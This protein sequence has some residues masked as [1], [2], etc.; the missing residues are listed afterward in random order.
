MR[1]VLY[2]TNGHRHFLHGN[3]QIVLGYETPSKG[4]EPTPKT[5]VM[6]M[7]LNCI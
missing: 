2:Y 1:R 4:M 7:A 6:S 3:T 5:G